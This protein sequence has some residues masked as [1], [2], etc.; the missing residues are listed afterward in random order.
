MLTTKQGSFDDLIFTFSMTYKKLML[1]FI[2]ESGDPGF[3]LE[4]GS[5]RY[6]TV[7]MVAF[8]DLEEAQLC[9]DR[10]RLLR[11]ELGYPQD[12]EFHFS[13][14]SHRVRL[15]FLEAMAPYT[16]FYFGI[17]IDKD[18]RKL[19]GEGFKY[20]ESFYKYT[21]RLVF[22]NA[23]PYLDNAIVVID[24]NGSKEFRRQLANYLRRKINEPDRRIIK[25]VKLQRS[26][27]NNLLQLADYVAG[28]I[29]RV[30][31]GKKFASD[32][33]RFIAHKEIYVQTWPK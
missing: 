2:D 6:F 27:S 24:K 9:D 18:P 25:K 31:Q 10:I 8:D 16:F 5:S 12:F 33:H 14:N 20:K 30:I 15:A 17:V 4:E 26:R 13:A 21:C 3:K 19:W 29:N 11:A 7:A 1:V 32:Y 22:E 23:K 28:V